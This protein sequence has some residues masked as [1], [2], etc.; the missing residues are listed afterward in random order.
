[1]KNQIDHG[2]AFVAF[3]Q[4]KGFALNNTGGLY[5]GYRSGSNIYVTPISYPSSSNFR[6]AFNSDGTVHNSETTYDITY[7]CVVILLN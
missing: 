4:P 6:I 1:M 3:F 2:Y 5:L 7:A